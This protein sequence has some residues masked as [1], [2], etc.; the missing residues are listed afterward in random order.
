MKNFKYIII[1]IL[2]GNGLCGVGQVP[3]TPGN[4]VVYRVGDGSSVLNSGATGVYLDEYTPTGTLVQSI[5]LPT[6]GSKKITMGGSTLNSGFLT[7]SSDGKY[8][9][10]P[11]FN[12]ST[13]TDLSGAGAECSIGLVDFNGGVSSITTIPQPSSGV[14]FMMS[15]AS[16]DG[17]N[18][19]FA[20]GQGIGYTTVGSSSATTIANQSNA[21]SIS[22]N[23]TNG[24]LYANL[25]GDRISKIGT[26]L[27]VTAGQ[28]FSGLPGNN[29]ISHNQFAFA[30]L[31]AT[32]PGVD[33]LYASSG[34]VPD[35]GLKKYSLVNGNWVLN[36]TIGTRTDRYS[37]LAVKVTGN[38]VTVFATR[39]GSN[40]VTVR[41]GQLISI[42]DNSGYNGAFSGTPTVLASVATADTKAFRGI[43]KV[44]TGCQSVSALRVPDISATQ[45]KIFW[46]APVNGGGNYEYAVT[47]SST[48]PSTGAITSATSA[49][50][51]GLT[52]ATTYYAHVRVS[53]SASSRSEWAT[54]SFVTGCKAPASPAVN[55]NITKTGVVDVKW[56]Q[57][58]GAAAYEYLISTTSIPPASGS[59][60]SDTSFSVSNLNAVTQYY[61]H[62]RSTCG[63]GTTSSWV[64]K[65][66][67]TGC[68][69]PTPSVTVLTKSAG[70][71]WNNI[72]NAVKYEYAVTFS[73][74]KPL[75]GTYTNDTV[76]LIDK[77]NDGTSYYFHV[78]AQCSTGAV[79][80]WNT[81]P[82]N[83]QGLQVYPNP[84]QNILQIR[85]NGTGSASAEVAI[86][87][88]MGRIVTR[89]RMN[90]N[91]ASLNMKGWAPGIYFVRYEDG[92]NKYLVRIVKQ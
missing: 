44:P 16:D 45:A 56:N 30:D 89:F 27:P 92:V 33:V 70:V 72:S 4:I 54:T 74:V 67:T 37:G 10:V 26:G 79:S 62:V 55:I 31:D 36:G 69:A 57:V 48:P 3:F 9:V 61:L 58:F 53:C 46:N 5:L 78:R 60:I 6:T 23:I 82:F 49:T 81:I 77:V 2:L 39:I 90:N 12:A 13:G 8:L 65:S 83:I 75:S 43:A 42:T 38:S 14:L 18:L 86:G 22:V 59:L 66:F 28:I 64:T 34:A 15:A 88:A 87:D 80:E 29:D 71:R 52:D 20:G 40:S 24:Q 17:S 41:G 11:G 76:Y 68:F 63:G 25:S 35:G 1:L 21:Y 47:T 84:V 85:L 7:L 19:W 51:T 73:P 32:V 91:Q 50:T